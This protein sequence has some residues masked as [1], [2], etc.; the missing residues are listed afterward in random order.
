FGRAGSG[1]RRIA[2]VSEYYLPHFGGIELHVRSLAQQLRRAGHEVTVVTPFPGPE[3]IDGIP[4]LRLGLPLLPFWQTVFTPRGIRPFDRLLRSGRFD[5]LHCHHSVYSPATACIAYLGQRAGVPTVVTFHSVLNGY[6]RAFAL[7][8]RGLGWN[9]WPMTLSAVSARL[10]RELAPLVPGRAVEILPNG[11]DPDAWPPRQAAPSSDLRVVST[12]RLVRRKRPRALVELLALVRERLPAGMRLRARIVGEG[13]ERA[14]LERLIAQLGLEG[15]V[16]LC[17]RLAHD[18]IRS[19]YADADVFVL[20]TLEESFGIAALEARAAGLPV[21]VL[22]ESGAAGFIEHERDGLLAD[23]D[24]EL[25][26]ALLRLARD[27]EL[28]AGI[29]AHNRQTPPPF[30]WQEVRRLHL[31]V[32]RN[33]MQEAACSSG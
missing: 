18:A 27:S 8:A 23:S 31:D 19:L 24:A 4:V 21:V 9:R 20:P 2:L 10:A 17:G 33:T 3:E 11:I 28:R 13:V 16:E 12:M 29:A 6:T 25:A 5:L 1:P 15:E 32:Y 7:W 22:R 30:A 14:P 26:A